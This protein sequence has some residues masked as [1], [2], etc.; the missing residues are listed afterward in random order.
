MD[1]TAALAAATSAWR[2]KQEPAAEAR[3]RS[4]VAA[5]AETAKGEP[6]FAAEAR[7]AAAAARADKEVLAGDPAR[8]RLAYTLAGLRA[9]TDA[10]AVGI[11]ADLPEFVTHGPGHHDALWELATLAAGGSVPLNPAE[12]FVLGAALLLFDLGVGSA[13]FPE[14]ADALRSD[15]A[16]PDIAAAQARRR[17][18]ANGRAVLDR[19]AE[20]ECFAELLGRRYAPR[21]EALAVAPFSGENGGG[22]FYLIDDATLRI[23]YGALIGQTAASRRWSLDELRQRLGR[24]EPVAPPAGLPADWSVEPLKVALLLRAADV[25]HFAAR[26]TP[27]ALRAARRRAGYAADHE[28]FLRHVAPPARDGE[29]VVVAPAEGARPLPASAASAW[30]AGYEMLE[31]AGRELRGIDTLLQDLGRPYRLA[32]RGVAGAEGPERLARHVP[33]EDWLPIDA[34]VQ[35]RDVAAL[36]KNLGGEHLY[37]DDPTVPLRELIQNGADAVRARRLLEKQG[38]DFGDVV[39]RRG[40]DAGGAYVEVEDNGI[41]MSTAVLTGPFLDFGTT[42]WG[43]ALM[44]DELPGLT[45]TD[46]HSTGRYGVGFFSVFMWGERV[47]VTTRR[48]EASPRDTHVLEFGD[49]FLARPLLRRASPAERREERGTTVRVY[50]DAGASFRRPGGTEWG[51]ADLLAYFCPALD[52]S[53]HVE[54]GGPG[55]R[56]TVVRAN[57][58]LTLSGADLLRRLWAHEPRAASAALTDDVLATLGANLSEVRA[59]W[60]ETVGRAAVYADALG[61]ERQRT[62]GEAGGPGGLTGVVTVGGFRTAAVSGI[63]GVLAGEPDTAAR[64]AA[65]PLAG[66][67]ALAEWA[68]GQASAVG[69][70]RNRPADLL[71][72]AAVIRACGGG[73]GD[74]PVARLGRRYVTR[75]EV[76]AWAAGVKEAVVAP[77][78][79]DAA[80]GPLTLPLGDV[81]L[82]PFARPALLGGAAGK[83]WPPAGAS[84]DGHPLGEHAAALAG[85]VVEAF[86]EAW[87]TTPEAVFAAARSEERE[88]GAEASGARVAREALVLTRP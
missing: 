9:R 25:L 8:A 87:G 3:R 4:A 73:V 48:Y 15:P 32:A 51:L 84:F 72:C 56:A 60:G 43:T 37:G 57:D 39:V 6:D 52:V 58:W 69:R 81:L 19:E 74:L 71:E 70:V 40:A 44:R 53:L 14:G 42:F 75:A 5:T 62:A 35:V 67:A 76:V 66:P 55:A 27:G 65:T 86:A 88:I 16:W 36:V 2:N 12:A 46:F 31:A 79:E 38:A 29:R 49:G 28:A 18:G 78:E 63:V 13:A 17:G 34:R 41:G 24:A 26:R 61:R 50:T 83:V 68:D 59:S 80:G 22:P 1:M 82:A 85:V 30:W 7:W 23:A 11:A 54:E 20:C 64:S 10:I 33:T 47:R 77:S 21:L 45:G